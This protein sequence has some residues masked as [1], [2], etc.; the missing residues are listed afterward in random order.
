MENMEYRGFSSDGC[1]YFD[2]NTMNY[3]RR[4]PTM[5][6]KK[7]RPLVVIEP[8][9]ADQSVFC[10]LQEFFQVIFQILKLTSTHVIWRLML[11]IMYIPIIIVLWSFFRRKYFMHQLKVHFPRWRVGIMEYYRWWIVPFW[12][13]IW[14]GLRVFY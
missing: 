5:Q 6:C 8:F 3:I 7:K 13:I 9:S 1:W 10:G 2:R 14:N 12:Y 11:I 4:I